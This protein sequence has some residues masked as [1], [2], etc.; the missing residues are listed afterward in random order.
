[1]VTLKLFYA[2]VNLIIFNFFTYYIDYKHKLSKQLSTNLKHYKLRPARDW[3]SLNVYIV[4][5]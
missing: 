3:E 1:M 5:L 4:G 2:P